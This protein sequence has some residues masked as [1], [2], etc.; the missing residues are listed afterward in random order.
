VFEDRRFAPTRNE[1]RLRFTEP[2]VPFQFT[3]E[4]KPDH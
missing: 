3:I 2:E 4:G 1:I